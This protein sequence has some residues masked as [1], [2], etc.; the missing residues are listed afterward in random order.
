MID[1]EMEAK[2]KEFFDNN[3]EILH[4]ESGHSITEDGKRRALEQV[5]YYWRKLK[6]IAKNV[7]DT[8]V[9]LTLPDQKTPKKRTYS[10][11]GVVDIVKEKDETWM[12]DIKTHEPEYIVAN[13]E[14]Y[15]EQINVYAHIWQKLRGNALDH[16]AII[17]TAYPKG[18]RDAFFYRDLDRFQQEMEKW[19]PVI[20]ISFTPEKVDKTIKDFGK[21]VDAIEESEFVPPEK[22]KLEEKAYGSTRAFGVQVCRNCDARFSC[23]AFR[24]YATDPKRKGR[25]EF[26]KYIELSGDDLEQEQWVNANLEALE[27]QIGEY[28]T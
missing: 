13:K 7:T 24:A 17:S 22:G 14:F 19:N 10:I 12:Y 1:Q 2:I 18:M 5:L 23:G 21:I 11:D 26:V 16:A 6:E 8:E 25:V 4:L 28:R 20:E 9:R 27:D 3:Y 15:E